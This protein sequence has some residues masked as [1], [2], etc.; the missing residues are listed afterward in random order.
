[1]EQADRRLAAQRRYRPLLQPLAWGYSGIQTFRR[2]AYRSGLM[3]SA[4]VSIPVI[5]VGSLHA[6]GSGKTPFTAFLCDQLS[7]H[8]VAILSRGYSG[9][10]DAS[11]QVTADSDPRVCGDEPVLLARRCRADV[12]VGRDRAQLARQV[13]RDYDVLMLDDG[14]QHLRLRRDLNICMVPNLPEESVLPAGLMRERGSALVDADF[15]VAVAALPEWV[16]RYY[17][18]PLGIVEFAPGSWQSA[19]GSGDPPD[20]VLAF[21]GIARPERFISSL[22]RFRLTEH[23]LFPDHHT[24][25]DAELADLWHRAAQGGAE[26]LVTTAKDAVRI[27]G[28]PEGLPVFWRDVEVQWVDGEAQFT[29]LLAGVLSESAKV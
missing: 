10:Y 5:S 15:V 21:A 24:F 13:E 17:D 23:V 29:R 28:F 12:W 9:T 20:T 7:N 2:R 4:A 11:Q 18:G 1:V 8:R 25:T 14:Y 22:E 16:R 27:G 3:Q 19:R 6:G 26:A